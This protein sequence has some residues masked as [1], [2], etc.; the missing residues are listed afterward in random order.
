MNLQEIKNNYNSTTEF[1]QTILDECVK[2]AQENPDFV[3]N[4]RK[5]S[6]GCLYNSPCVYCVGEE[7]GDQEYG[8]DCSGCIIGQALQRMGWS[9]EKE[10]SSVELVDGL[11]KHFI[12]TVESTQILDRLLIIQMAQ[13][14]GDSWASAV[15]DGLNYIPNES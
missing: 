14:G 8:P 15:S 10:L 4:P 9:D 1:F 13:D 7:G 12:D 2:L 11:L 6:G 5:T 3:Y